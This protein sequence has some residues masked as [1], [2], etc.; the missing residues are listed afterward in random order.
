MFIVILERLKKSVYSRDR[1]HCFSFKCVLE[2]TNTTRQG[3][4]QYFRVWKHT[5]DTEKAV[6][7]RKDNSQSEP[8]I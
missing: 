3:S 8:A 5:E 6:M 2:E 4:S 1:K 7:F